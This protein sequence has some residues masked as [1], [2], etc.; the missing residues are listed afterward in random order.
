MIDYN[1]INSAYEHKV[2]RL[3]FLGST[4]IYPRSVE[5][6]MREDAMLTNVLEPTNEPYALSKIQVLNFMNHTTVNM[7]QV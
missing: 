7:V 1:I 2:K 6:P 4:C 5:Q 3:L